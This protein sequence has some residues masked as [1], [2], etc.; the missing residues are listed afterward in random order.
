[1]IHKTILNV[2]LAEKISFEELKESFAKI[3]LSKDIK[4]KQDPCILHVICKDI[5]SAKVLYD[6][7]K[8]VG[9]KRSGIISLGKN[10]VVEINSTDKLEFPLVRNGKLLVDDEFLEVI[11][12]EVNRK[13]DKSWEKIEKLEKSLP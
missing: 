4:F 5:D 13:L 12:S 11:V 1:M 10:I 6:T 9:W 3:D 8:N 2:L 7:A